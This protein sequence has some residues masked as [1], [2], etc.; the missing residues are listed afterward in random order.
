MR[1]FVLGNIA[2]DETYS[3]AAL[4]QAGQSIFGA[5][6]SRDLGGKGCNQAIVMARAGLSTQLI[7]AIGTDDRAVTLRDS[8]TTEPVL[9]HLIS[10][11]GAASDLSIIL[12][13]PDGENSIIT[14]RDAASSVRPQQAQAALN[15]SQPGD[16]LVLQ[17]NLPEETTRAALETARG[18][19]MTTAFNP[20]PLQPWFS[21]L[22][23]LID[24]AFL[25]QGEAQALTGRTGPEA[26]A[27]LVAA[28]VS[29]IVLTLGGE[30][31]LL[32]TS[33]GSVAVPACASAVIDTTGA[34]DCFMGTALA[35]SLLRNVPLDARALEDAAKAAAVTVSRRGTRQAF[36]S[37]PELAAILKG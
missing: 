12:T 2:L 4:P 26:G 22:W 16:L 13:T 28:G 29:R 23:P 7:A 25:N 24:I 8:L 3:L 17:G 31:A 27:I 11:D 33:E 36:P 37:V 15:V 21:S 30:G 20:S 19:G 5:Q 14:T 34:G 35:S 6:A 18:K 10:I 9:A 32:V 1:A